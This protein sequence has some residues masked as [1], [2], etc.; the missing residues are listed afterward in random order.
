[1]PALSGRRRAAAILA[2]LDTSVVAYV[3]APDCSPR[4]R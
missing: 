1:M 4:G 2:A 3:T